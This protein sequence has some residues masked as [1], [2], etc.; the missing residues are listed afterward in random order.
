[1]PSL[2]MVWEIA[3]TII[4]P[5][6]LVPCGWRKHIDAEFGSNLMSNTPHM[7]TRLARLTTRWDKLCNDL[8]AP[9]I[10]ALGR[11]KI[12]KPKP[13]RPDR[14]FDGVNRGQPCLV[15][16]PIEPAACP[17]A[18]TF[19]FVDFQEGTH[20]RITLDGTVDLNTLSR[21]LTIPTGASVSDASRREVLD[22]VNGGDGPVLPSVEGED[23][24]IRIQPTNI[25]PYSAIVHLSG[26][27]CSGA[28]IGDDVVLTAAHCVANGGHCKDPG[29]QEVYFENT[30]IPGMDRD[31][32]A[33][34][35]DESL[36]TRLMPFGEFEVDSALIPEGWFDPTGADVCQGFFLYDPY[37]WI[38]DIA[39]VFLSQPAGQQTGYF[40]YDAKSAPLLENGAFLNR[41][42]PTPVGIEQPPNYQAWQLF[43]DSNYCKVLS[44]AGSVNGV[45]HLFRHSC[46]TSGGHSGSPIFQWIFSLDQPPRPEIVGVV[47]HHDGVRNYAKRITT[48]DPLPAFSQIMGLTFG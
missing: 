24:R 40:D 8:P 39:V 19:R 47:S 25:F 29:Y 44:F 15:S 22:L 10:E 3:Q 13:S 42:Y 46:D 26:V 32:D 14:G 16:R 17:S 6:V 5:S 36:D 12:K 9:R 21:R 2:Q 33:E 43:G 18:S 48:S 11:A 38:D 30:V 31:P 1:M 23:T 4:V 20:Y 34:D 37:W 35:G 7:P 27:I 45:H 41:G 28:M